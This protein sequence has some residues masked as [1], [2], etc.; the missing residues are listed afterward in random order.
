MFEVKVEYVRCIDDDGYVWF[1]ESEE[2]MVG[3]MWDMG[4]SEEER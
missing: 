4:L 1:D 3:Y 2:E